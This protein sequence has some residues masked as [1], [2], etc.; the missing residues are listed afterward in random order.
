MRKCGKS[1]AIS[2][3]VSYNNGR[4]MKTKEDLNAIRNAMK[5]AEFMEPE[6]VSGKELEKVSGG[7]S[8]KIILPGTKITK[9]V[10]SSCGCSR[11][12]EGN[13][14]FRTFE[15][16]ECHENTFMGKNLE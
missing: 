7:A 14:V 1:V 5:G 15:C 9:M 12:W 6:K 8:P 11:R 13:F 16:P 10:C 3:S 2:F 4:V